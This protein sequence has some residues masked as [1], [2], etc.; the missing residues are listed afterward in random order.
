MMCRGSAVFA[1]STSKIIA[2]VKSPKVSNSLKMCCLQYDVTKFLRGGC[3]TLK[4]Q[5]YS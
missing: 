4:I 2:L 1:V 5:G 3:S